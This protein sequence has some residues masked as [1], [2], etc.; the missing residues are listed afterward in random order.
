MFTNPEFSKVS[1]ARLHRLHDDIFD[2]SARGAPKFIKRELDTC[3]QLMDAAKKTVDFGNGPDLRPKNHHLPR[4][5]YASTTF[6]ECSRLVHFLT[7]H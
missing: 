6:P 4:G 7:Q 5:L 1:T 3:P 2:A